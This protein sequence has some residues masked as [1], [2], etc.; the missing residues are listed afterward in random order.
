M[1]RRSKELAYLAKSTKGKKRKNNSTGNYR[2][3]VGVTEFLRMVV[4]VL[5]VL[6]ILALGILALTR[7][8]WE[9]SPNPEML[10]FESW[11]ECEKNSKEKCVNL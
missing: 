4:L 3:R 9:S 7:E 2:G 6:V 8:K 5:L 11:S 10:G 1:K